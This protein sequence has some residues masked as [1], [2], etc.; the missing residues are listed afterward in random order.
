M[1]PGES[2]R[3]LIPPAV[4]YGRCDFPCFI[5]GDGSV[6][7]RTCCGHSRALLVPLRRRDGT[8][9]A[10]VSRFYGRRRSSSLTAPLLIAA[11]VATT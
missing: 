8:R 10:A 9:E 4:G 7:L 2:R 11:T 5:F 6:V 3:A 1:R